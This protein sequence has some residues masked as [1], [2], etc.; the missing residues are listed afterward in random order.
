MVVDG[1]RPPFNA[2]RQPEVLV[3]NALRK[4]KPQIVPLR[5]KVHFGG[6]LSANPRKLLQILDG[7]RGG[8]SQIRVPRV[9]MLQRQVVW[10]ANGKYV[11]V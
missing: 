3:Q 7:K 8:R 10:R 6:V 4:Q 11:V 2:V 9:P 5:R 1:K